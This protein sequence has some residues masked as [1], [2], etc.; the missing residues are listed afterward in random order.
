MVEEGWSEDDITAR[1]VSGKAAWGERRGA[2]SLCIECW[3]A[4]KRVDA[5]GIWMGG[6]EGILGKSIGRFFGVMMRHRWRSLG[7]SAQ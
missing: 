7:F 6:R 4:G 3:C 1:N 5:S 2:D